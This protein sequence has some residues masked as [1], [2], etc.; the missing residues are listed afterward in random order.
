MGVKKPVVVKGYY[1]ESITQAAHRLPRGTYRWR[2]N[3]VSMRVHSDD[4]PEWR[5]ATEEE[6]KA[7]AMRKLC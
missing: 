6:I 3:E 2:R 5:F 4:Y 1:F 7:R